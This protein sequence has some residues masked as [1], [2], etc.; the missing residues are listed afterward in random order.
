MNSVEQLRG[1]DCISV[2]ASTLHTKFGACIVNQGSES[3][4]L[5]TAMP[6]LSCSEV[7]KGEEGVWK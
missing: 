7:L 3:V 5:Q 1:F 2:V 4:V 6:Q